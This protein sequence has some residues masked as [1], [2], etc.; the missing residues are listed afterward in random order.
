MGEHSEEMVDTYD[1]LGHVVTRGVYNRKDA[2]N[3]T[4]RDSNQNLF[5]Q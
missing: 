1:I 2:L 3:S 4:D 5:K